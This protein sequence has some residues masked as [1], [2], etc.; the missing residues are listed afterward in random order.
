MNVYGKTG[1]FAVFYHTLTNDRLK[2]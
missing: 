2:K 1:I